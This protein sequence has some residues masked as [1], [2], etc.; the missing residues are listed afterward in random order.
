MEESIS[1]EE[2]N[3]IRV[4]LGLKPLVG[5]S[6]GPTKNSEKLA[7]ANYA[8]QRAAERKQRE[9]K[10]VPTA[11]FKRCNRNATNVYIHIFRQ[12]VERIAK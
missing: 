8:N 4:S 3:K 12:I 5:D 2:T 6:D 11:H 9:S 10:C 7:E 1:I